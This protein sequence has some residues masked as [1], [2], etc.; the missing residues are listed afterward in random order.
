MPGRKINNKTLVDRFGRTHNYLRF[1]ITDDCN[2]ACTY[3]RPDGNSCTKSNNILSVDEFE[4]ICTVFINLGIK[5]IRITGGEPLVRRD[6]NEIANVL[7]KFNIEK[8][9]T[10]NG[11]LFD[12]YFETL[13]KN[14][15][16]RIN[17]SLDTLKDERF[18]E[19]TGNRYLSRV[20]ENIQLAV[21]KGFLVKLNVVVIK[22]TNDDEL[23]DFVNLAIKLQITVR[24]IEFMPFKENNWKFGSMVRHDDI[25][26]NISSKFN[27]IPDTLLQSEPAKYYSIK[28]Q[29]GRIG[30]ISTVSQP[31][32]DNCNR[33]R[34]TADGKIKSCLFG[35]SETDLREALRNKQDM[36]EFIKNSLVSKALKHGGK[37]PFESNNDVNFNRSM[38]SIGG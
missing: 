1:S 28:G 12:C 15:I 9:I 20:K 27:L 21:D 36:S 19:I 7:G 30:I 14:N 25:L 38:Y 4:E 26:Q 17:I 10:T 22:G 23:T 24:F 16:N 13:K 11:L 6:F 3:C 2:F 29:K 32:C 35:H 18:F 8:A 33:I 37:K 34:V 5:K 31:F